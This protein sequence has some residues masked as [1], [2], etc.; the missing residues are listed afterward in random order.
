MNEDDISDLE[1][2]RVQHIDCGREDEETG[3]SLLLVDKYAPTSS[4]GL[5]IHSRKIDQVRS[6][7]R[8]LTTNQSPCILVLTGPSGSAKSSI[9]KCFAKVRRSR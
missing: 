1:E 7:F 4:S 6:W 3:Q 8:S 5:A 9:V 2:D